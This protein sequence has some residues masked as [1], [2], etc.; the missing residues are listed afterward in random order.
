MVLKIPSTG[1][2]GRGSEGEVVGSAGASGLPAGALAALAEAGAETA[3][4]DLLAEAARVNGVA[5][6]L[7]KERMKEVRHRI[8][9][10]CR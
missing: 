1:R 10:T 5:G 8:L 4:D 3:L 9:K 7:C 6:G 2:L